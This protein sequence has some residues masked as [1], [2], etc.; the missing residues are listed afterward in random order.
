[1]IS[2]VDNNIIGGMP[3]ACQGQHLGHIVNNGQQFAVLHASVIVKKP[4]KSQSNQKKIHRD[5]QK[6]SDKNPKSFKEKSQNVHPEVQKKLLRNPK[7]FRKKRKFSR[8]KNLK[9]TQTKSENSIFLLQ[10]IQNKS[11]SS[12][13]CLG[14]EKYLDSG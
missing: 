2:T 6:I 8:T 7:F 11:E 5:S 4:K 14:G 13:I 9:Y 10:K 12:Q 1:M 3:G